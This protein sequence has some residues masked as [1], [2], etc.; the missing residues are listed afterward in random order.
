MQEQ[1]KTKIKRI[2]KIAITTIAV[3]LV[4]G[5]AVLYWPEQKT[6]IIDPKE[7]KI[8]EIKNRPEFI[9]RVN[10]EAEKIYYQE[11][12]T[13]AEDKLKNLE[14]FEASEAKQI[15]VLQRYLAET[16]PELVKYAEEIVKLPRWIDIMGI[17]SKETSTCTAGVGSSRN[18]CGAIK[19]TAGSFK[20]YN[21]KLESIQDIAILLQKPIYAD[22][23]I[24]EINGVYCQDSSQAG[25]KCVGWSEHI[26]QVIEKLKDELA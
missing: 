17:I 5:T 26:L 13:E 14:G 6:V 24:E 15:S 11:Q 22:K 8:N 16:N 25:K 2:G 4:T 21:N 3:I 12:K 18:N 20:I 19:N 9:E 7:E 1:T 10:Q 23:T